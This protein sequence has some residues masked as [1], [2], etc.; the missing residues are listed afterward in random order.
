MRTAATCDILAFQSDDLAMH[1]WVTSI[2]YSQTCTS[3]LVTTNRFRRLSH[4]ARARWSERHGTD[5]RN[6]C[7]CNRNKHLHCFFHGVSKGCHLHR[8]ACPL[9]GPPWEHREG[10]LS[11]QL[12]FSDNGLCEI[13]FF[14]QRAGRRGKHVALAS[15]RFIMARPYW[16]Q[17]DAR[18]AAEWSTGDFV[19]ECHNRY[20]R[21]HSA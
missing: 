1:K 19:L 2:A 6:C 4:C 16:S 10:A 11:H 20:W 12:P 5:S 15:M 14:G 17:S 18:Q 21:C 9:R 8:V 3:S 13:A 7:K